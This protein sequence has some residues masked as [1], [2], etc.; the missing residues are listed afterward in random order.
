MLSQIE[1]KLPLIVACMAGTVAWAFLPS[2]GANSALAMQKLDRI[3][4][5][6]FDLATF[7][8]GSLFAVYVLALSRAE[9][10]L[11]RIF[12]TKTF[13]I[14]NA[15]VANSIILSVVLAGA[16]IWLIADGPQAYQTTSEKWV[17]WLW[18]ALTG[19][20]FASA[21]RVVFMFLFIVRSGSSSPLG[22]SKVPA[23]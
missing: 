7:S 3:V 13:R 1:R 2:E 20:A 6:V 21:M 4:G 8:A 23:P 18:L 10:F 5:P 11:G 9:G 12:K 17:I 19:A 22:K 15:Y 14:F 16:S